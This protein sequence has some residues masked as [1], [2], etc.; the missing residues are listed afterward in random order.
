MSMAAA[1]KAARA[2]ELRAGSCWRSSCC[3]RARR[4]TCCAPLASSAPL[5]RVHAY[6]RARVPTLDARPSAV[7]RHRD[8]RGD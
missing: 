2:L 6:I 8:D 5:M 4:S 3:A 7:A 1:L